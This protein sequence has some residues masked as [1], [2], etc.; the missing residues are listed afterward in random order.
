VPDYYLDPIYLDET[1]LMFDITTNVNSEIA[2][3]YL[4]PEFGFYLDLT[5]SDAGSTLA[6]LM[7]D[8]SQSADNK[9]R[10]EL[11]FFYYDL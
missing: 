8:G 9:M 6:Q 5:Q 4:D 10:L 7:L 1:Y 11:T 3:Y 2:D